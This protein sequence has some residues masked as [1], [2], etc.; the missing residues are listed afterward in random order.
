V[1]EA[2]VIPIYLDDTVFP[3]IPRDIVGIP[4]RLGDT[5]AQELDN[6]VTDEIVFKLMSRLDDV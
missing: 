4:F 2:A 5:P 3:R 1:P 6:R